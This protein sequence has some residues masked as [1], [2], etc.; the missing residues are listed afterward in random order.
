MLPAT[1]RRYADAIAAWIG[2]R[3]DTPLRVMEAGAG[4]GQTALW[5]ATQ[6]NELDHLTVVDLDVR[7]L[8]ALR[9]RLGMEA[10][11]LPVEYL[12][13]DACELPYVA[14][15]SLDLVCSDTMLNMLG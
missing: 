8:G 9:P 3:R 1:K 6:L 2:P 12:A 7:N 11:F 5:V 14:T 13:G 10:P 4:A 15:G